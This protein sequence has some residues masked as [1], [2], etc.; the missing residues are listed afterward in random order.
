MQILL[1]NYSTFGSKS[2]KIYANKITIRLS[3]ILL[4]KL[5]FK[6]CLNF[7]YSG[8]FDTWVNIKIG[9]RKILK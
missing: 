6:L 2:Q 7:R 5:L 8:K 1:L 4:F 9:V 3:I